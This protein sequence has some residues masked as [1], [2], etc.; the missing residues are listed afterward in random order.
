MM[1]AGLHH[2]ELVFLF[3]PSA[4]LAEQVGV[5]TFCSALLPKSLVE[6]NEAE[7]SQSMPSGISFFIDIINT[8]LTYTHSLVQHT[9]I[10][11]LPKAPIMSRKT[12]IWRQLKGVC[13]G[14]W[15]KPIASSMAVQEHNFQL[16]FVYECEGVIPKG[17]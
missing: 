16:R 2:E 9:L 11:T 17:K 6:W 7:R 10:L 8:R 1:G 3:H 14:C 4:K 15:E 12:H 5:A 13:R